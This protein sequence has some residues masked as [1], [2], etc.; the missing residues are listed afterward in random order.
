VATGKAAGGLAVAAGVTAIA[1]QLQIRIPSR[2]ELGESFVPRPEVARISA[3]GFRAVMA[4]YY[5]LQA[6]QVVGGAER[7]PSEH[8]SFLGRLIDVVTTVDPWV[9]HPYRFAAVWMVDTEK[10]VRAANQILARGIAHHPREWRNRFYLGFNHFFYLEEN[11]RAADVL[12]PAIP[13]PGAPTYLKR[14]VARLRAETDGLETAAA[15]L[16]ELIESTQDEYARA[17]YEKALDEIETERRARFLDAAREEYRRRAGADIGSVEDLVRGPHRVLSELPPEP[18]GWE[19][20]L[21]EQ[22]GRIVSTYYWSRYETHVHP[23]DRERRR[24]WRDERNRE[25]GST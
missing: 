21:S 12:E 5:W 22:D 17:E 19:W 6:V 9:G 15:F 10:S 24:R 11:A 16:A 25:G 13:L 18:N 8:A 7:D 2:A 14:L 4:D 3:L 1:L 23:V 20:A